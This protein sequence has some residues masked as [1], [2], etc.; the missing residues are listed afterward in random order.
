MLTGEPDAG[1]LHVRFGGRGGA[2][3]CAI[4]TPY[5]IPG[6]HSGNICKILVAFGGTPVLPGSRTIPDVLRASAKPC[7]V[8]SPGHCWRKAMPSAMLP[9]R[10]WCRLAWA[11]PS[12]GT[13]GAA[14]AAVAFVS[15]L[16]AFVNCHAEAERKQTISRNAIAEGR[17]KLFP[18]R[19]ARR[20]RFRQTNDNLSRKRLPGRSSGRSVSWPRIAGGEIGQA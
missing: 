2:N 1:N 13:L 8:R 20:F 3:Q 16:A 17:S 12:T 4:P 10:F 14:S 18:P 7:L 6:P 19:R 9:L 5:Q 15:D 11:L